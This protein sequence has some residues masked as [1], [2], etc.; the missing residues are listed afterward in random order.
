M[1]RS[2]VGRPWGQ[3]LDFSARLRCSNRALISSGVSGSPVPAR[4]E[5]VPRIRRSQRATARPPSRATM[6]Q[7][8][9][10]AHPPA[11]QS[12]GRATRFPATSQ[13]SRPVCRPPRLRQEAPHEKQCDGCD[14]RR[15]ERRPGR[16]VCGAAD[17]S[18]HVRQPRPQRRSD[19]KAQPVQ[20]D[21]PILLRERTRVPATSMSS[22]ITTRPHSETVVIAPQ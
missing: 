1:R 2:T 21:E 14:H 11:G 4:R 7:G 13:V 16:S 3:L 12:S 9:K 5:P 10:G 15:P 20:Q 18:A 8:R 6:D 19:H 17:T 22:D